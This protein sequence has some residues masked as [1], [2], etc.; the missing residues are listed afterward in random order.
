MYPKQALVLVNRGGCDGNDV[1]RLAN[2]VIADIEAMF[3]VRLL[4]EAIIISD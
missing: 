2:A 3:G 1:Q 4:P